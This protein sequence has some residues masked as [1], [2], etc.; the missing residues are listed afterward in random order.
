MLISFSLQDVQKTLV[1]LDDL[2]K[3]LLRNE[4]VW[5]LV[6]FS[7]KFLRFPQVAVRS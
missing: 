3:F 6:K 5:V 1:F 2:N 4:A 7:E